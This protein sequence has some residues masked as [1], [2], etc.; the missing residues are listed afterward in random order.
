MKEKFRTIPMRLNTESWNAIERTL[1]ELPVWDA[2]VD[3]TTRLIAVPIAE[4]MRYIVAVT[5]RGVSVWIESQELSA[6][7][8]DVTKG[9]TDDQD[10]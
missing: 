1:R 10:A 9:N 8:I 7:L 6:P 4:R 2:T 3:P 5:K